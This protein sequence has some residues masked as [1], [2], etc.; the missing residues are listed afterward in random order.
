MSYSGCKARTLPVE[1]GPA[2]LEEMF[3]IVVDRML[4]MCLWG[5]GLY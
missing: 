1:A 4:L 5:G 3:D 2:A